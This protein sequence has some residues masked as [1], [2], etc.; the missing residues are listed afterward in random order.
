MDPPTSPST[1]ASDSLPSVNPLPIVDRKDVFFYQADDTR[2]V[3]RAILL[4][5]EP[6]VINASILQSPYGRMFNP[7][8]IYISPEGAGAGNIWP[9]GYQA[10][11]SI[12]D[13]LIDMLDREAEGAESLEGFMLV[14]SIAGGTGSGMGSFLLERINERYPKKLIQTYSVFPPTNQASDVVVQPYN[15]LLTLQRLAT[16]ADSTVV[17]DNNALNRIAAEVVGGGDGSTSFDQLNQL[18]ST[19][20]A[21]TTAPLR[22]PGYMH[23]DLASLHAAL[24][25]YPK[26]HFLM[27]AYTPFARQGTNGSSQLVR[28][29]TVLDVMRRLLQPKNRMVN[30]TGQSSRS[31]YIALLNIIQGDDIDPT[32]IHKSLLRIRER[33]LAPFIPSCPTSL[34]L[35]LTKRSSYLSTPANGTNTI[36]GLMLANH[37]SMAGCLQRILDQFDRLYKRKAFVDPFKRL[38][39]DYEAEFDHARSVVADVVRE[40]ESLEPDEDY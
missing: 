33:Q 37:T 9:A 7:E 19:V 39:D 2:Y 35:S 25:P 29:T 21:A 23:N 1:A 24:I 31:R 5:L 12:A 18:V 38:L 20:M 11:E 4:D 22:F 17:I 13:D 36:S 32:D 14:H 8:N 30:H 28:K 27:T 6:K 10:A 34:Q 26:C 15:A 40:Y 3:P 16:Y